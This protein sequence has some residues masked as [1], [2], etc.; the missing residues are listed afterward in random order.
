MTLAR[1][2][3]LGFAGWLQLAPSVAR[4]EEP[5]P[6]TSS[7][8]WV[9]PAGAEGC[10]STPALARSVEERLRR[11]VFVSAAA[12]HVSVEGLVRPVARPAGWTATLTLR[13]A[14]GAPLGTR[15]IHRDGAD[16]HVLDASLALVIAVMIDPDA[17]PDEPAPAAPTPPPAPAPEPRTVVEKEIV[18]VEVPAKPVPPPK[19]WRFDGGAAATLLVGPLPGAAFGAEAHGLLV[20]PGW[21]AL[22]GY[23]A[24]YPG[25]TKAIA[26]GGET[27]VSFAVL[28]GGICPLQHHGDRLHAYA[29]V[30][31]QLGVISA[32]SKGLTVD[33][34]NEH[35][36]F[37]ASAV[38]MRAS[39][40]LV[41]PLAVRAGAGFVVPWLRHRFE[42]VDGAGAE[43]ELHRMAPVAFQTDL[44]LGVIFP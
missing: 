40:R 38:A 16:C 13:D 15:E 4:A 14:S 19:P 10:I 9:R 44:G 12:A 5:A 41:G 27:T 37:L 7:L 33:V 32:R 2:V 34:P 26:G 35:L 42:Y 29:C 22:E 3:V 8:S 1:A 28:G 20:P 31:G 25:S 11:P 21:P 18:R 43:R 6:R 23:G 17:R 24:I 30:Q 39:L 36:P